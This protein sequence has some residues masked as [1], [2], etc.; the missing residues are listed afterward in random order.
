[1]M[2]NK[3]T[4]KFDQRVSVQKDKRAQKEIRGLFL[5]EEEVI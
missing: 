1:M 5:K 2:E 3:A 4:L